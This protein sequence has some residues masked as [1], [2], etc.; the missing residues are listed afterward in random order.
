MSSRFMRFKDGKAKALTLSYDD[1]VKQDIR[2]IDILDKH[3]IKATF[4]INAGCFA[5]EETSKG[6]RMTKERAYNLYKDSQHEV[7][8]HGYTHPFL[9]TLSTNNAVYEIIEDRRQLEEMFGTIIRGCAYPQGAY[10]D[11]VVEVLRL[12]GI[13]YA[14]TVISTEGFNIPTDWLRLPATCKHTNPRLFE[15]TDKFI[16]GQNLRRPWLFYLWGHSYE[17]DNDDNWD[18]IEKFAQ[19]MGDRDDI[20]YATNI[21]IFD[22]IEAYSA[23]H[24]SADGTMVYNPTLIDVWMCNNGQTYCIKS[25]ET[26]VIK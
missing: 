16:E 7:A 12:C 5:A 20:W 9:D 18:V 19:K 17:F 8:I 25:G 24:T 1:G 10:S 15:L 3:G 26:V 4:N 13:K 14:R 22:Y 2:L 6:N 11:S 23:L 21:E